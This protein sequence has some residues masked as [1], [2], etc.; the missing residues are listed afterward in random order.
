MSLALVYAEAIAAGYPELP[1]GYHYRRSPWRGSGGP[2][3]M[4]FRADATS[5]LPFSQSD[6]AAKGDEVVL[7]LAGAPSIS[8]RPLIPNAGVRMK[9]PCQ[10]LHCPEFAKWWC[11]PENANEDDD[12]VLTCDAHIASA[13]LTVLKGRP[14][15]RFFYVVR[16][17]DVGGS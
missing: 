5:A 8:A 10:E 13:G 16:I 17:G 4:V 15:A 11:R 3:F 2:E 1:D 12:F 9:L 7:A 14:P 6:V